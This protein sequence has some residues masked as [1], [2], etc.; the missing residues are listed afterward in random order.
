METSLKQILCSLWNLKL[1]SLRFLF[2][3]NPIFDPLM[4]CIFSGKV[5]QCIWTFLSPYI[6]ANVIIFIGSES[7]TTLR[8]PA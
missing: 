8:R 5:I 6:D 2:K 3:L 7:Q 4:V 1:Q